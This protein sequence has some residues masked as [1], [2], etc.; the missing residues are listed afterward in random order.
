MVEWMLR[1]AASAHDLRYIALRYFNV[2]G[3]DP[4]GRAG[5]A[6]PQ[7]THL[8]KVACEAAA[9]KREEVEIFG[10]DYD[11]PDGTCIRGF[12]HVSDL[13]RSH[14]NALAYLRDHW[15]RLTLHS[16]YVP[17]TSLREELAWVRGR[18]E[19]Q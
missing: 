14:V 10:N 7:A 2:A 8:V 12:V 18:P 6:T 17:R 9:G 16:G 5:Q 11:T 13:A 4:L 1:D 19:E 3:A 15:E